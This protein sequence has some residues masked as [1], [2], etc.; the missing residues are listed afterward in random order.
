MLGD[1]EYSRKA[2]KEM[3]GLGLNSASPQSKHAPGALKL[4]KF[5]LEDENYVERIKR[6]YKMFKATVDGQPARMPDPDER[7]PIP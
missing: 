1:S 5:I 2:V 4:V 6:H 7:S 3:T